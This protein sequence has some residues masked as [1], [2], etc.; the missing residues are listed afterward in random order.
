MENSKGKILVVD[1]EKSM[2]EILQIFLKNEGYNVSVAN[3]G[4]SAIEV[5]KKDIFNLIITDMK[6]PKVGGLELLKNVKKITPDTVVVLIT[7][8]GTTES[9]VESMKHGT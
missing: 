8:F 1:D 7:A 9:A 2:R 4:S 6:M 3:N 5:L